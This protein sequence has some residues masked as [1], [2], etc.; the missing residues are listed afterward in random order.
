MGDHASP[1]GLSHSAGLRCAP[2]V[3]VGSDAGANPA[4]LLKVRDHLLANAPRCAV[5]RADWLRECAL[6]RDTLP[7][8]ARFALDA[9]EL[10]GMARRAGTHGSDGGKALAFSHEGSNFCLRELPPLHPAGRAQLGSF[11]VAPWLEPNLNL[12]GT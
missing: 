5:V 11:I 7:S 12:C 2:S 3:Q 9:P 10:Q 4:A 8:D 6:R 1:V